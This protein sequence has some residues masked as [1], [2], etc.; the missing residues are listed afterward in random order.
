MVDFYYREKI[1][2]I[3][4]IPSTGELYGLPIGPRGNFQ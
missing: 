4:P 3:L 2:G 1:K